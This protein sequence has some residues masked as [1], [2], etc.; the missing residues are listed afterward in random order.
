MKWRL[1]FATAVLFCS[2]ALADSVDAVPGTAMKAI[3]TGFWEIASGGPIIEIAAC[4]EGALC[5]KIVQLGARNSA[6]D[7]NNPDTVLRGRAL[8]RLVVLRAKADEGRLYNVSDG[9]EYIIRVSTVRSDVARVVGST[10]GQF[11]AR[12]FPYQE[13]WK[14]IGQ[15]DK[16]CH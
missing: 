11:Y 1:G 16:P 2:T 6:L 13:N 9:T 10:T 14:R 15:P 12:I 5:G 7:A 8:C 3:P 4:G